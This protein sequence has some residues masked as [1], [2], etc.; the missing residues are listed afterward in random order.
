MGKRNT[1][2]TI[3]FYPDEKYFD[4]NKFVLRRC[5]IPCTPRQYCVQVL[6]NFHDEKSGASES[7]QY[8]G[9]LGDY[10]LETLTNEKTTNRAFHPSMEKDKVADWAVIWLPDMDRVNESYA[11]LIPTIQGGTHVNGFRSGLYEAM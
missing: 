7:W 5:N 3:R 8:T 1:G 4:S 9:G 2:T 6:I 11:N 10:L